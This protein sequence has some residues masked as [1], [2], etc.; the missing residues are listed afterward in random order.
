MSIEIH[1]RNKNGLR[2]LQEKDKIWDRKIEVS[3]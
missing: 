3:L 2:T 1:K